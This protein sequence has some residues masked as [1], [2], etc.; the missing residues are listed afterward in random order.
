MF[1][2][3]L[4]GKDA[5]SKASILCRLP[6]MTTGL[7][8]ATYAQELMKIKPPSMTKPQWAV[9]LLWVKGRHSC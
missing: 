3:K 4:R 8:G 1:W 2:A 9:P 7:L 5:K 6:G